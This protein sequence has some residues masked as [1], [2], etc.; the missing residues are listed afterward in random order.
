[1]VDSQEIKDV[2]ELDSR[3]SGGNQFDEDIRTSVSDRLLE[4]Y[5][6][7]AEAE[8]MAQKTA[9][10]LTTSHYYGHALKLANAVNGRQGKNRITVNYDSF[11]LMKYSLDTDVDE[12]LDQRVADLFVTILNTYLADKQELPSSSPRKAAGMLSR[13]KTLMIMLV[14]TNQYG[15][16]PLLNIPRYIFYKVTELFDNIQE[17]KEDVLDSWIQWLID[18]DNKKMADIAAAAGNEFWGSEGIKANV[19]YDRHYGRM[20][21][22][23]KKPIE[24]YDKYLH[25]R[26]EY[27]KSTKNIQPSKIYDIFD[28]TPDSY[29]RARRNVYK[30][31]TDLFPEDSNIKAIQRLIF[32]N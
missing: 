11:K 27:R 12:I 2:T 9:A 21:E 16:I 23:I 7:I 10:L 1:M 29:N 19:M 24:T 22:D 31:I 17:I 32:E 4:V 6:Q 13:V 3:E 8:D 14:V 25:F 30:E 26:S 15:L 28:I 20:R 18:N 5:D